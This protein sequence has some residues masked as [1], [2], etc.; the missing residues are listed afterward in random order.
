MLRHVP[1]YIS[2]CLDFVRMLALSGVKL[3][4][5][6]GCVVGYVPLE[7][8]GDHIAGDVMIELTDLFSNVAQKGVAGQ[9]TKH[10]DEKH[11]TS[12]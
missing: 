10:H 6:W 11:G 7:H 1:H 8:V 5:Y 2:L 4:D 9:A 3:R 12:T